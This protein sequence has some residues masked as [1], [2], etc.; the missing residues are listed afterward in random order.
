MT[1]F[2]WAN[3]RALDRA[4]FESRTID[5]PTGA[6]HYWTKGEGV[7]LVLLHGAGDSGGGWARVAPVLAEDFRVVVVDLP[8]HG[9]SAPSEGPLDMS[10]ILAGT[11]ALLDEVG[12]ETTV[13]V[14]NSL[15][16]WLACLLAVERPGD[17]DRIVAVNGGPLRFENTT[18]T[19]L[20]S[21]RE[22]ARALLDALRDDGA[23]PVTDN[24]LDDLIEWSA[25][26][27]IGRLFA[28][29]DD[30]SSH[31]L[32]GRMAE[33]GVPVDVVWGMSDDLF[34]QEY[35]RRMVAELPAARLTWIEACGHTPAMECPQAFLDTLREVL[36]QPAP[37]EASAAETP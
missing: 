5:A 19:L 15:G 1:L 7:T 8:G 4:G 28:S 18:V 24:V 14:G 26:G 30:L 31:V 37:A 27:P 34:P 17:L 6:V 3:R 23:P 35:A 29:Y 21:T 2:V 25:E 11:D 10:T 22:E 32:D 13:L 33:V 16:A 36:A 9:D 20:P 12:A